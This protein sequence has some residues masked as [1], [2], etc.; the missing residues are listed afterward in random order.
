MLSIWTSLKFRCPVDIKPFPKQQIL[1]SSNLKKFADD[2]FDFD[3][4]GGKFSK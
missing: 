1:D 3:E 2:N 4:N